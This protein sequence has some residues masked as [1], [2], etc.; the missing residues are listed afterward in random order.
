MPHLDAEIGFHVFVWA[1]RE[2]SAKSLVKERLG[3]LGVVQGDRVEGEVAGVEHHAVLAAKVDR[4]RAVVAAMATTP[5]ARHVARAGRREF[6]GCDK[7]RCQRHRCA[8][9]HRRKTLGLR[10]GPECWTSI[11]SVLQLFKL[12]SLP[13]DLLLLSPQQSRYFV[14]FSTLRGVVVALNTG[15]SSRRG[16]RWRGNVLRVRMWSEGIDRPSH[17]DRDKGPE[18]G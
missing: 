8:C 7:V 5:F 4:Q 18:Q 1:D 12:G 15:P 2:P 9:G 14:E 10:R 3:L 17:C 13:V 6:T 16:C 11:Q